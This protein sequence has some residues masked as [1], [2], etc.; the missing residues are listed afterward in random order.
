MM[1]RVGIRGVLAAAL[2]VA[3]IAGSALADPKG[4]WLSRLR[5]AASEDGGWGAGQASRM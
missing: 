5:P 2:M 4:V 3:G 1:G